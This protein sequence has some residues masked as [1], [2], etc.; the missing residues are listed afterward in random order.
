MS[1]SD[2]DFLRYSRQILLEECGIEGQQKLAKSRVLVVGCGGLGSPVAQYL[3]SAGV[4]KLYLADFDK[5]DL[6]NLQRQT[7]FGMKDLNK[8]KSEQARLNLQA[9]NPSVEVVAINKQLTTDNLTYW[10]NKVNVVL[11]CSDNMATRHAVNKVCVENQ[12]P[13]ISGSAVGMDGQLLG[14]FPPYQHGCYACLFSDTEIGNLNCRT[15]GV[16]AP[17]V[18][19][20]GSLQ[21]LEA[22]K[23]LLGLPVSCD[24]K[25]GVFDGRSLMWQ[26]IEMVKDKRCRV[27]GTL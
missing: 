20:I 13:L 19:I 11:D 22:L 7:L 5:V 21:A 16:L 9:I 6:T 12:I 24:G 25:F 10:V 1:L 2:Q 3:A 26:Q 17:I 23:F 15:A 27:C 4:G 8:P 14:V 18:G